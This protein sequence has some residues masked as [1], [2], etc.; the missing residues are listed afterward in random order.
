MILMPAILL[1][2]LLPREG[3]VSRLTSVVG[4]YAATS[5]NHRAEFRIVVLG[6]P[7]AGEGKDERFKTWMQRREVPLLDLSHLW[8]DRS[9]LIPL[10]Y[11]FNES[12]SRSAAGGASM[13]LALSCR[14][15]L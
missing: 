2:D 6:N 12:G 1:T 13:R 5:R 10:E 7:V 3:E 8:N 4:Q 15:P 14:W 9:N 11:H